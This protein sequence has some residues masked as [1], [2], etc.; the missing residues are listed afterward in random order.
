VQYL[1]LAVEVE[2]ETE[3]GEESE[4]MKEAKELLSK[5]K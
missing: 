5:N 2:D 3:D 4:S 1:K